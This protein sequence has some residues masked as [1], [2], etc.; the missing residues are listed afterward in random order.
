MDTRP[1]RPAAAG[2][3][4]WGRALALVGLAGLAITQPVLDLMGRNPEFFVAGSYTSAQII[5]FGA[6]VALVPS[7]AL[8]VVFGLARLTH[9]RLGTA[10]Y[11]LL[12]ALLGALF[13]NVLL[14]GLGFDDVRLA[15]LAALLG[16]TAVVLVARARG[17]QLLLQYLAV[18]NVFF[19]VAF[20]LTSPVGALVSADDSAGELG[21]VRVPQPPGPV[22]VVVFDELPVSTLMHV[23]GTI[24]AER[25]P[26]FARL[27]DR[28]T[29]FRN[30]SS[31]HNRTERAVPALVTGTIIETRAMPTFRDLP[32]NLL[33]LMGTAMPV[34]RYESVTDLCPRDTCA[35]RESKPL[36][37]ALGDSLVVYGHRVLPPEL[38]EDLAPID[39]AWGDFGG[40]GVGGTP[41]GIPP[42]EGAVDLADPQDP[43]AS[44]NPLARWHGSDS[45][46]RN[47]STQ[48]RRLVEHGLRIGP[49]PALHF[50]HVVLPHA[51]WSATPWATSLMPPMPDWDDAGQADDAAWSGL[52]RYQ[53]HSLQTGA[54]DVALGQVLEHLDESGVW[55]DA[56]VVVTADHGTSTI[57][58]DV[59]RVAT[60]RNLEEVYRVPLFLKVPGQQE[61]TVV[62]DLANIVDLLPTLMDVLGIAADW[63]MDGHSLLDGSEPTVE[64]LGEPGVDALFEV[65]RRHAADF[66]HG[67]DWA[68]LAAVGE[69]GGLVGR[70]LGEL[71]V[72][73][74][75]D[76]DWVPNNEPALASLPNE[77]GETP[78]L[79]TGVVQSRRDGEPPSVVIVAN[80]TVAGVT[81]GYDQTDDGWTFSSVLG[82]YLV[83]GA[84]HLEAYEV[85][86]IDGRPVLHPLG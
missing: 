33:A 16:A 8:I 53:R 9:P 5:Q 25:Y 23:D 35:A 60:E 75:S 48:A 83:R 58:P 70:P 37:T 29:W 57:P 12:V 18:A 61:A 77:R 76:M 50:I 27:A 19:L 65:V 11:L 39:D 54:A 44:N 45:S 85:T 80:G 15:V 47:P 71:D 10:V 64:P 30:A 51:P 2:P 7:V 38:R 24:N 59:G 1:A 36:R 86:E 63:E 6:F 68:A 42:S 28:S 13:G 74:P 43:F 32:R 46:E 62:D 4:A 67:W 69:H 82:P 84:N 14:R 22:V 73:E 26:A 3:S 31:P 41:A 17:G 52:I 34:E 20:L 21:R 78:Q 49:D 72:G 40:D 79:V 81:G 66:P 55:D 56:T